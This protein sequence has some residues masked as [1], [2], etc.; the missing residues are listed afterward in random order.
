[1]LV[2]RAYV[3][4]TGI[5]RLKLNSKLQAGKRSPAVGVSSQFSD[6]HNAQL[7]DKR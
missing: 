6:L 2:P 3:N 4:L 5:Y 7:D 1:M